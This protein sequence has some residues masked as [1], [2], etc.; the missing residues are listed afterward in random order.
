MPDYKPEKYDDTECSGS[1]V[2]SETVRLCE[3]DHARIQR[4]R[5]LWHKQRFRIIVKAV[6]VT[7]VLTL[8]FTGVWPRPPLNGHHFGPILPRKSVVLGNTAGFGPDVDYN[9]HEMLW[10]ATEMSHI[11]Q[12]W[13][14]LFPSIHLQPL[15]SDLTITIEGRGYVVV[16]EHDNYD[17]LHP[18]F[19]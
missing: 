6:L 1:S 7:T 5:P 14:K 12:N 16:D 19:K 9:N 15:Y 13:Q 10:N 17:F 2:S 8:S 11:H 3:E 18:P 4:P